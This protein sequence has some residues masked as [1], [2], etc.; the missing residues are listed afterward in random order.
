MG[1]TRRMGIKEESQVRADPLIPVLHSSIKL[2]S[3]VKKDQQQSRIQTK[4]A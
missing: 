4:G 3:I 2:V 1:K